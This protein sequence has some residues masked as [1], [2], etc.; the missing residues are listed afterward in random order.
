MIEIVFVFLTTIDPLLFNIYIRF[1]ASFI[2]IFMTVSALKTPLFACMMLVFATLAC[3][4]NQTTSEIAPDVMVLEPTADVQIEDNVSSQLTLGINEV[5]AYKDSQDFLHI[6]GLITNDS[7]VTIRD[8]EVEIEVFDTSNNVIHTGKTT[9]AVTHITPQGTAPFE[10]IV[11]DPL[12]NPSSFAA[13]VTNASVLES[14]PA[15]LNQ[16]Q[17]IVIVEDGRN[18]HITGEIYNNTVRPVRLHGVAVAI[19][20]EEGQLVAASPADVSI[21]YLRSAEKGPFRITVPI[22]PAIGNVSTLSAQIYYDAEISE[23]NQP[24]NVNLTPLSSYVDAQNDVH[25]VGNVV[26][27]SDEFITV[28]VVAGVYDENS[29][30]I[31]AAMTDTALYAIPPGESIPYDLC[32]SGSLCSW[33]PL[34]SIDDAKANAANYLVQLDQTFTW[35]TDVQLTSL[36]VVDASQEYTAEAA[37]FKGQLIN[38]TNVAVETPTVVIAIR[39]AETGALLST[40][41]QRFSQ[42][43]GVNESVAYEVRIQW[44]PNTDPSNIDYSFI[45]RGEVR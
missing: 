36:Q 18:L 11:T 20:S 4:F 32:G 31:D 41:F 43:L 28:R 34:R 23:V 44:P 22:P 17:G 37:I 10:L 12:A 2:D 6:I 7:D 8:L 14:Y 33:G 3:N 39:H 1:F 35:A 16:P 25:I 19:R 29:N 9:S 5:Y 24:Y 40:G 42:T 13:R 38:N 15:G 45:A 21:G 26:N 30:V 27:N